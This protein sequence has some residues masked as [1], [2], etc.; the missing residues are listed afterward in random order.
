MVYD[1]KVGKANVWQIH[2]Q[3]VFYLVII[4]QNKL[5]T[6]LISCQKPFVC[7]QKIHSSSF[8]VLHCN[9]RGLKTIFYLFVCLASF[10][11][12]C[13]MFITETDI[14]PMIPSNKVSLEG[15]TLFRQD[16]V[17]TEGTKY[18]RGG[19][20]IYIQCHI[21]SSHLNLP[22]SAGE[23]TL[24]VRVIFPIVWLLGL[25]IASKLSYQ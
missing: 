15:Y 7:P 25:Y 17:R 24:W 11:K 14:N 10:V 4:N 19:V 23:I 5:W 16:P 13:I 1:F 22:N 20:S 3:C 21:P 2:W 18:V 12:P 6:K 9:V 8:T